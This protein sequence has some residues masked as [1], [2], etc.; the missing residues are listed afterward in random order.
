LK[1]AP[2]RFGSQ[3]IHYQGSLYSA[4]L[5]ITRMILSCPLAWTSSVLRQHILTRCAC[6]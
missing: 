5:K 3:R 6:V 4:W 1:S 2:T